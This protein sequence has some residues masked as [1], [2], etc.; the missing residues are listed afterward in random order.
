MDIVKI[1]SLPR[2]II[3]LIMVKSDVLGAFV[4]KCVSQKWYKIMWESLKRYGYISINKTTDMSTDM[5]TPSIRFY[6]A[7]LNSY[8]N[9]MKWLKEERQINNNII[10]DLADKNQL[11]SLK[12]LYEL[13]DINDEPLFWGI[14]IHHFETIKWLHTNNIKWDAAMYSSAIAK[15]CFEILQFLII[16]KR[17]HDN[18][19]F[20]SL[21]MMCGIFCR[22][23]ILEW[24]KP[25]TA[26]QCYPY[27]SITMTPNYLDLNLELNN[28]DISDFNDV[29]INDFNDE[30]NDNEIDTSDMPPLEP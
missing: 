19:N 13:G 27:P 6:E 3:L 15:N 4:C 25:Y 21:T 23:E 11:K 9:I 22:P 16:N 20:M 18:I 17:P 29:D 7:A 12:Y 10:E 8:T 26:R 1:D 2:E 28:V 30:Y 5:S 24:L 14:E